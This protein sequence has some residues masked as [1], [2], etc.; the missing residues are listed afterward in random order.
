DRMPRELRGRVG[1]FEPGSLVS[2]ED[3]LRRSNTR[4]VV[5]CAGRQADPI[6]ELARHRAPAHQA[7][8]PTISRRRVAYRSDVDLHERFAG[9]PAEI[10]ATAH[11]LCPEGGA[12][13]F[14]ASRAV[15][16]NEVAQWSADLESHRAA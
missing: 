9:D 8:I 11:D 15:I 4:I 10:R 14:P 1:D 5:E 12:A 7:E 3:V 13:R 16:Q 6:A 2:D